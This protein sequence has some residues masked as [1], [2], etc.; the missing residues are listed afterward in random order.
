[1]AVAA[2]FLTACNSQSGSTSGSYSTAIKAE[3]NRVTAL[4]AV[5][6]LSDK[7]I[8]PMFEVCATD[9]TDYGN[10][11]EKAMKN[12]DTIK[13]GLKTFLAA[14]PDYKETD[15]MAFAHGDSVIVTG[16]VTGTFKN[17]MMGMKPTGKSFKYND[18]D[19]FSFNKDGKMTSHRSIQGNATFFAQ[20]GVPMPEKK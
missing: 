11:E 20:L 19:I 7:K 17:A 16:T 14:F 13:A 3:K 18:A 1:M 5:Q 10:G 6:N 9:F 12:I 15:L 4:T 2:C 8:D